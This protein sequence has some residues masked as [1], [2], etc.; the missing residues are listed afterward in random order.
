LDSDPACFDADSRHYRQHDMSLA[1][2]DEIDGGA[3]QVRALPMIGLITQ[4]QRS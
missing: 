4:T 1:M 3:P 2:T